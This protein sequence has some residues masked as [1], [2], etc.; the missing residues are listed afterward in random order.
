MM[1][2]H[3]TEELKNLK[4]EVKYEENRRKLLYAE[5]ELQMMREDRKAESIKVLMSL[6]KKYDISSDDIELLMDVCK[7][8]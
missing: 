7:A 3:D 1:E 4:E 5:N 8:I 2:A 6:C